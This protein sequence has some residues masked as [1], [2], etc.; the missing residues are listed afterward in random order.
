MTSAYS[1]ERL[2][3]FAQAVEHR[4]LRS[5]ANQIGCGE[6]TLAIQ[7]RRLEYDLGGLLLNPTEN[8]RLL[9][10]TGLG[11]QVLKALGQLNDEELN[12]LV[13][14]RPGGRPEQSP[15]PP[16]ECLT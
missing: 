8:R 11:K 12:D 4:T 15:E 10:P 2:L 7:I 1:C 13:K 3:R 5:A 9:Q 16:T 6:D 14:H